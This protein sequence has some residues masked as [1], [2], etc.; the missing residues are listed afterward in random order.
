MK[1]LIADKFSEDH[2]ERLR[3]AGHEVSLQPN[4]SKSDLPKTIAGF[5]VLVVRSTRVTE[6]TI[7]AADK[8]NLII[9]AGAGVNTIALE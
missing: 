5:N 4:L 6:E 3:N 7:G 8:L 2:I 9:R 1:V